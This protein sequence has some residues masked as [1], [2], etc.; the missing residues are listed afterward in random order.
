MVTYNESTNEPFSLAASFLMNNN[1]S[2]EGF[3]MNTWLNGA[4]KSEV[5]QMVEE[6]SEMVRADELR[7]FVQ[8]DKFSQ[9]TDAVAAATSPAADRTPVML[10]DQ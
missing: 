5:T 1:I 10:M 9:V 3:N 8:K 6:L 4:A 2:L 7:L